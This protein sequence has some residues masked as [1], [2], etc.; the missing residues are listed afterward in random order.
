MFVTPILLGAVVLW[1]KSQF[2]TKADALTERNRVAGELTSIRQ[3]IKTEAVRVDAALGQQKAERDGRYDTIK[4]K[5][6]DHEARIK[7]GEVEH[8]RPPSRHDL[9]NL[10]STMQ[11]AVMAMERAVTDLGVRV[12]N[13]AGETRRQMDTFGSYL[14]TIIDKHVQ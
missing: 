1:L 7:A 12:D 6:S 2:V 8:A 9:R 10:I 11:G 4:D 13:H 14:H 5:L 3:D